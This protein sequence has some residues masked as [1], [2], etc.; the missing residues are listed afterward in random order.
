[1]NAVSQRPDAQEK[2]EDVHKEHAPEDNA[3]AESLDLPEGSDRDY[4]K[5]DRR[6]E[7]TIGVPSFLLQQSYITDEWVLSR[8]HRKELSACTGKECEIGALFG[9]VPTNPPNYHCLVAFLKNC[10]S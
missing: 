3:R 2:R 8:Y 5:G 7:I 9:T 6:K 1:M 10:C 4:V